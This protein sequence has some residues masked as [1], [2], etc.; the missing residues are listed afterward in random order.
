[1]IG[2][3]NGLFA[4]VSAGKIILTFIL[5]SPLALK[6]KLSPIGESFHAN[7]LR[8]LAKCCQSISNA[9]GFERQLDCA[10]A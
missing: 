1:L 5:F 10:S 9:I 6:M 4:S 2:L 8:F 7:R 3:Q